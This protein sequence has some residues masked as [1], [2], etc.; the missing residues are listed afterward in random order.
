[1]AQRL[2][3]SRMVV[4][5]AYECLAADGFIETIAGGGTFITSHINLSQKGSNLF[6]EPHRRTDILPDKPVKINFRPGLPALDL[7]PRE[8]WKKSISKALMQTEDDLLGYG[9]VE[10]L[11]RLRRLIASYVALPRPL[12]YC[13]GRWLR[14]TISL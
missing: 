12:I 8:T 13:S 4:V 2:Q 1:M 6:R 9:P 5:E 7:F 10:G 11:P 3:V 14:L